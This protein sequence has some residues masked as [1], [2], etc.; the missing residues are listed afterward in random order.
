MKK[1]I[2]FL[3]VAGCYACSCWPQ[4]VPPQYLPA[5]LSCEAYLPN[6]LEYV[7]VINPCGDA[8]LMQNPV[9][10]TILDVTNPHEEVTLTAINSFGNIDEE[11]FDVFL[12]AMPEIIWDSIPSDTIP[13]PPVVDNVNEIDT[14]WDSYVTYRA[15]LGDTIKQD[16]TWKPLK[17]WYLY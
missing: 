9:P 15:H 6:Y 1:V 11:K 8:T 14:N 13:L 16:S 5:N 17:Y 10:G 3:I 12:T 4:Q 2:I 7:S